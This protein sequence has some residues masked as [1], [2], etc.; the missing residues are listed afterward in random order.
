MNKFDTLAFK[1]EIMKKT[2]KALKSLQESK[3]IKSSST[4]STYREFLI[5]NKMLHDGNFLV[6]L[7]KKYLQPSNETGYQEFY[8]IIAESIT[9][10][11]KL[12][13]ETDIQPKLI[14]PALNYDKALTESTKLEIYKE[15]FITALNKNYS[16]P[17]L[18]GKLL[19]IHEKET[20]LLLES[21]AIAGELNIDMD[22]FIKYALFESTLYDT[23][24]NILIPE[25]T[26]KEISSFIG[27]QS[28]EYFEMF[29]ENA[30]V[31]FKQLNENIQKLTIAIGPMM[32]NEANGISLVTEGSLSNLSTN[33]IDSENLEDKIVI[34]DPTDPTGP[35]QA[36]T[37]DN[38]DTLADQQ[39]ITVTPD[40]E[41]SDIGVGDEDSNPVTTEDIEASVDP[42]VINPSTNDGNLTEAPELE[43][44]KPYEPA[45]KLMD[46]VSETPSII[47]ELEAE[48]GIKNIIALEDEPEE[49][50]NV[51]VDQSYTEESTSFQQDEVNDAPFSFSQFAGA[52]KIFKQF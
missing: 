42:E 2:S 37:I 40:M 16:Q 6:S 3:T 7:G 1:N 51:P 34:N 30:T 10:Y 48:D 33:D 52:M 43:T 8:S 29:N 49:Y 25:F 15:H 32:F 17:L 21:A 27:A 22:M 28:P 36:G 44:D 14:S 9:I 11:N 50:I 23:L 31:L 5:E 46:T 47:D 24:S 39:V 38:I 35:L 13:M 26:R 19:T 41:T 20:K 45:D 18:E 4:N 12:C